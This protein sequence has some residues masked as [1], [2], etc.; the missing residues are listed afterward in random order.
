MSSENPYEWSNEFVIQAFARAC[1]ESGTA[2]SGLVIDICAGMKAERA[3][4]LAGVLRA[5][6]DAVKPSFKAG[7][8]VKPIRKARSIDPRFDSMA[9]LS[10]DK[11]YRIRLVWYGGNGKWAFTLN[12]LES[13][14]GP[15][16]K[17]NADDFSSVPVETATALSA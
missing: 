11:I 5:R 16:P 17:Y 8:I 9:T 7:D 2:N 4:H 1:A 12:D 3:S 14:S 13:A 6:L 10:L 15:D